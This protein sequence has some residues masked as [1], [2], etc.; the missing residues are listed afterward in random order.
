M[1]L[2]IVHLKKIIKMKTKKEKFLSV[3]KQ[4]LFHFTFLV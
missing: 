3:L 4:N 2:K 1:R